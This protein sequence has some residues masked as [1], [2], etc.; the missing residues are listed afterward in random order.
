MHNFFET[1]TNTDN[2]GCSYSIKEDNGSINF[3]MRVG[4]VTLKANV[5][6]K[7]IVESLSLDLNSIVFGELD[8]ISLYI[9]KD[10]E[11]LL[12]L[13][14]TEKRLYS[15]KYSLLFGRDSKHSLSTRLQDEKLEHEYVLEMF[16]HEKSTNNNS[17]KINNTNYF[18]ANLK[19][20]SDRSFRREIENRYENIRP[21]FEKTS[22][23]QTL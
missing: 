10:E 1:I 3:K 11:E 6:C 8:R 5:L 23:V 19:S 12:P 15:A 2:P 21:L 14:I 22:S 18:D 17:F 9:Q 13:F 7:N 16:R 4:D 20:S